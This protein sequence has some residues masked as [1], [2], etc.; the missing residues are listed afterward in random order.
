MDIFSYTKKAR[1]IL[2]DL[3]RE[4]PKYLL[5][6]SISAQLDFILDDFNSAG[7]PKKAADKESVKKIIL[8]V[9]A[10]REIEVGNPKLADLLCEID[11]EYKKLYG[12][13]T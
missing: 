10:V 4:N 3:E 9:Q 7:E 13:V 1:L 8:G 12:L 2:T 11:Y 6:K 5:R